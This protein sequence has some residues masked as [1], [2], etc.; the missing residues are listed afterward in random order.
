MYGA[1]KRKD[2]KY[3]YA[4]FVV[5]APLSWSSRGGACNDLKLMSPCMRR[6]SYMYETGVVHEASTYK[7]TSSISRR[8]RDEQT[9]YVI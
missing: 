2:Q 5:A 7:N 1:R 3:V 8:T 6:R 9:L 4:R